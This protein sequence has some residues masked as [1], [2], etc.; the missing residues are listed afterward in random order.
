MKIY[1][2]YGNR[3]D[4]GG[5][6][7]YYQHVATPN[8]QQQTNL[9]AKQFWQG[10]SRQITDC[11]LT[12][13][14]GTLWNWVPYGRLIVLGMG[15]VAGV[16]D[17]F[18]Y[19]PLNPIR[20]DE[21]SYR[22]VE[23]LSQ[24]DVQNIV[25]C[26]ATVAL[27]T[28]IEGCGLH[29]PSLFDT[30]EDNYTTGQ[31]Y[32]QL[33]AADAAV[34]TRFKQFYTD[35]P[36]HLEYLI[37]SPNDLVYNSEAWISVLLTGSRNLATS[38]WVAYE[39]FYGGDANQRRA[40]DR[41]AQ[42]LAG[43]PNFV[44]PQLRAAI[45][46]ARGKTITELAGQQT[47]PVPVR[48][49]AS[50]TTNLAEV[51]Y[52]SGEELFFL[53]G[54]KTSDRM[55][56]L[57]L[58][59]TR[60]VSLA[61]L[62][63]LRRLDKPG[64]LDMILSRSPT[65]ILNQLLDQI[66][67][68][69][70]IIGQHQNPLYMSAPW[71]YSLW[72]NG[73][74][75]AHAS[76][77]TFVDY[78]YVKLTALAV[79]AE[80]AATYLNT[81]YS[82]LVNR[83]HYAEI[84]AGSDGTYAEV[85]AAE[86][87]VALFKNVCLNLSSFVITAPETYAPFELVPVHQKGFSYYSA[88]PHS[89]PAPAL[90]SPAVGTKIKS[91]GWAPI[92]YDQ[93]DTQKL[94]RYVDYAIM[95]EMWML[96][97]IQGWAEMTAT[98]IST[99]IST[100]AMVGIQAKM[101]KIEEFNQQ[102]LTTGGKFLF[103]L[104]RIAEEVFEETV[105][106]PIV[107]EWLL[108]ML[109]GIKS[110][111]GQQI[112]N[113]L[114]FSDVKAMRGAIE[115][116][117]EARAL[118]GTAVKV[119]FMAQVKAAVATLHNEAGWQQLRAAMSATQATWQAGE[120]EGESWFAK[121]K[122]AFRAFLDVIMGGPEALAQRAPRVFDAAAA[123]QVP[124]ARG[125]AGETRSISCMMDGH[126]IPLAARGDM[127][128]RQLQA[129][130]AA[131]Y[132]ARGIPGKAL[133]DARRFQGQDIRNDPNM[134]AAV[135]ATGDVRVATRMRI[136][137]LSAPLVIDKSTPG[138]GD[139]SKTIYDLAAA[140]AVQVVMVVLGLT[141]EAAEQWVAEN[142]D[143]R[144]LVD[145]YLFI[146]SGGD[147]FVRGDPRN[148]APA[149]W[150]TFAALTELTG[151]LAAKSSIVAVKLELYVNRLRMNA[152]FTGSKMTLRDVF[153][154]NQEEAAEVGLPILRDILRVADQHGLFVEGYDQFGNRLPLSQFMDVP[155]TQLGVDGSILRAYD[156]LSVNKQQALMNDNAWDMYDKKTAAENKIF[157]KQIIE[158]IR[159]V[160]R[161]AFDTIARENGIDPKA[162][163]NDPPVKKLII[164]AET[165]FQEA[166]IKLASALPSGYKMSSLRQDN[167]GGI[168]FS[169][170]PAEVGNY[171]R[172]I[173]MGQALSF[174]SQEIM[175]FVKNYLTSKLTSTPENAYDL[176]R[177]IKGLTNPSNILGEMGETFILRK[178]ISKTT[179]PPGIE[180]L[181]VGFSTTLDQ[182]LPGYEFHGTIDR[183][184]MYFESEVDGFL[185]FEYNGKKYLLVTEAKSTQSD[186]YYG[187]YRKAMTQYSNKIEKIKNDVFLFM[188]GITVI[189][190][191]VMTGFNTWAFN[192][193][194]KPPN[195]NNLLVYD[196]CFYYATVPSYPRR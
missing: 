7:R 148:L 58:K 166:F 1:P 144:S 40:T 126:R 116:A 96:K 120:I 141:Q 85:M 123:T 102:R 38:S 176:A 25:Y 105:A 82:T 27:F 174:S 66:S 104:K 173:F 122:Q 93:D 83:T 183:P 9:A 134:N 67:I 193:S 65:H 103:V 194:M 186:S 195:Y 11:M 190:A 59:W 191:S 109:S 37:P 29:V 187:Q 52:S 150:I 111:A 44:I 162:R 179:A 119:A 74:K 175:D 152:Q 92:D 79:Q 33:A 113:D 156:P 98:I 69:K 26:N 99:A 77:P 180:I 72:F 169:N 24:V 161:D 15:V 54:L 45:L 133:A 81:T 14:L 94:M 6:P 50:F 196:G 86:A 49:G 8:K 2:S 181:D 22:N 137:E 60:L 3:A 143:V 115:M 64:N 154:S 35:H 63:H 17:A 68:D 185:L 19:D 71:L 177:K 12:T 189:T 114:R 10:V 142:V 18:V 100:A 136:N 73:V 135:S 170:L 43:Y 146:D 163:T 171:I 149:G 138:F 159:K 125:A 87:T 23:Y 95:R 140:Q 80:K 30:P 131:M 155:L 28:Y 97:D 61:A 70:S 46:N 56:W 132:Q 107:G 108:T 89:F 118:M 48:P 55:A 158:T 129:A 41:I 127:T 90:H 75:A 88:M 172:N 91:S 157:Q 178:F 4:D 182:F 47:I 130:I 101:G 168:D 34:G 36:P 124:G 20:Q 57:N 117:L 53:E 184:R 145:Q 153:V 32:S 106:E 110:G 31:Y 164:E 39:R 139:P 84:P 42:E 5:T 165:R 112:G 16:V 62:N 78:D 21:V 76:D 13:L 192:P 147:T 121:A 167:I 160:V 188:N 51:L 128:I 151:D